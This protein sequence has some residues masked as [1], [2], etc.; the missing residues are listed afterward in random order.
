[1]S[2]EDEDASEV[3][4]GTLPIINKQWMRMRLLMAFTNNDSRSDREGS[5]ND[6]FGWWRSVYFSICEHFLFNYSDITLCRR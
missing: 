6:E 2:N 4:A 1:M 3:I 5:V